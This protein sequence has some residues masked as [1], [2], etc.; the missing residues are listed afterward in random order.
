MVSDQNTNE[1]QK[2]G[3]PP[4]SGFFGRRLKMQS[5]SE[6]LQPEAAP[7]PPPSN[8]KRPSQRRPTLSAISGIFTFLLVALVG[9]MGSLAYVQQQFGAPGPL[10]ADK[11]VMI[12]RGA[13]GGDIIALLESEGI[14]DNGVML[15][16]ALWMQGARSKLRSGEYL[17]RKEASLREIV[18]TLVS[19]REILH[20]VSVP[21][22]LTS[23]QIV[24]R[25]RD[26]EFL[27]GEIVETPKEGSLLPDTYRI[28]RGMARSDLIRK[29]QEEQK[30]TLEQIWSRRIADL[31]VRSPYEMVT[32][33]SIVEKETGKADER[34]RV[35]SVFINRLQKRMRLQSDPTI[36]YG[37]V[38]GKGTL[39]RG[40]LRSE[41]DRAT[42]YNTYAIEGL[43]PGP[44]ANPGRAALEAV[45]RPSRTKDLYFVADGTGGHVFAETLDQHNRNVVRWRQL[46]K[47]ARERARAPAVA[48]VDRIEGEEPAAAAP[49]TAAPARGQRGD[50]EA[51]AS[52][53]FAGGIFGGLPSRLAQEEPIASAP[54]PVQ[55]ARVAPAASSAEAARVPASP[56]DDAVRGPQDASGARGR[57]FPLSKQIDNRI[58]AEF[59]PPDFSGGDTQPQ[60][61]EPPIDMSSVPVSAQRRAEQKARA[62]R[63]GASAGDDE[64]PV[65]AYSHESEA[66]QGQSGPQPAPLPMPKVTRIYD[67]SEGTRLDPLKDNSWDLNSPKEVPVFHAEAQAAAP[68]PA[69]TAPP[70]RTAKPAPAAARN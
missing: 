7:P 64:L 61:G 47:D 52:G 12:P 57:S 66:A 58:L 33:A 44:I 8:T 53:N 34:P 32:L 68:K 50:L 54:V 31:P 42:P 37:L 6:A 23:E 70:R 21:E 16:A 10:Q 60:A 59:T 41:V 26:S 46:E 63:Y 4:S 15:N 48:P 69:K 2:P 51:P 13:D 18:D 5:P 55:T 3:E 65:L 49:P 67:A 45:A 38:G 1:P 56:R 11:V 14:V 19:G 35:A 9:G 36:V 30:K 20:S 29:M 62:A 27:T 28:S 17:F 39:G 25:L 24:Q 40:I 43:P 22:G